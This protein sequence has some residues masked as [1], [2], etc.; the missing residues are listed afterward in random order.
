MNF[1]EVCKPKNVRD[2]VPD[3]EQDL[4]LLELIV[5]AQVT[6]PSP[7][8]RAIL[9]HGAYG[10]GKTELA[11]LLAKHIEASRV[12]DFDEDL[13]FETFYSCSA[14]GGSALAQEAMPTA[15]SFNKSGRHYIILDEIDNLGKQAQKNMKG[16][17]TKY[18][19]VVY[20]MTTNHLERV[21]AG[22]RSRAYLISFER[23]SRE[24]WL[25]RCQALLQEFDVP[26]EEAFLK[27]VVHRSQGDARQILAE[28]ETYVLKHRVRQAS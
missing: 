11:Q 19:H 6:F 28:L 20:I 5:T 12:D 1:Y 21:D 9:L 22:L 18:D 23:P 8:K 27:D 2:F 3:S 26:G 16:F 25:A 10:S 4:E 13:F 14:T 17:I 15:V 7:A 24:L